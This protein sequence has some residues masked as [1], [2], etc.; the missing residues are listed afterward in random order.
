MYDKV[1]RVEASRRRRLRKRQQ[2]R[3][4]PRERRQQEMGERE[5]LQTRQ[6]EEQLRGGGGGRQQGPYARRGRKSYSRTKIDL[7]RT[8]VYA[9]MHD[10][11]LALVWA[12]SPGVG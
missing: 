2:Q 10:A 7:R 12:A 4:M 1:E 8:S 9:G 6:T 5:Q 11:D 3:E